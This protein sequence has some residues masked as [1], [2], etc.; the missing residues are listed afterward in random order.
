[1]KPEKVNASLFWT[2]V[3]LN[4]NPSSESIHFK[5]KTF[6]NSL[7]S[8]LGF[9]CQDALNWALSSLGHFIRNSVQLLGNPNSSSPNRTTAAGEDDSQQQQPLRRGRRGSQGGKTPPQRRFQL[10]GQSPEPH[11]TD[12]GLKISRSVPTTCRGSWLHLQKRGKIKKKKK[13]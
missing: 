13:L 3:R 8:S 9:V 10:F 12:S 5:R 6:T 11:H 1:M 4:S 2:S 7:K